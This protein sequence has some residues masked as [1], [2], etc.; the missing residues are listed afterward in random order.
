MGT[1]GAEGRFDQNHK[2]HHRMVEVPPAPTIVHKL[3]RRNGE[4]VESIIR[5]MQMVTEMR[6]EN[7]GVEEGEGAAVEE[8]T[9]G[10]DAPPAG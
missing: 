7:P 8:G 1:T 2:P 5:L 4:S 9:G 3:A 10:G 6:E